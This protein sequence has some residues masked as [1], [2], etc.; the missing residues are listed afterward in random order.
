MDLWLDSTVMEMAGD[1][2]QPLRSSV[3]GGGWGVEGIWGEGEDFKGFTRVL[4][5]EEIIKG[6]IMGI[7]I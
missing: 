1:L 2:Y 3:W 7:I 6:D 4:A 5:L